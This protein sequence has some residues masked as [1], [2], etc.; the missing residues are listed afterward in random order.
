MEERRALWWA[1]ALTVVGNI[2][3]IAVW[4][5]VPSAA[6]NQ[7]TSMATHAASLASIMLTG[8]PWLYALTLSVATVSQFR[9]P[10][11]QPSDVRPQV[12]AGILLVFAVGWVL[13]QPWFLPTTASYYWGVV[14]AAGSEVSS[15]VGRMLQVY[16]VYR[17]I[18]QGLAWLA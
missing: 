8:L 12:F 3:G 6:P 17:A 16:A 4:V 13:R 7:Y 14:A 9:R 5:N 18:R 15:V 11:G 2:W 10:A 1:V